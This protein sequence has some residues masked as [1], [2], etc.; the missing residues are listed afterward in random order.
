M[1][2]VHLEHTDETTNIGRKAF[3][4]YNG[5]TFRLNITDSPINCS[6]SW[7]G[8]S[9][10]Y[11]RFIRLSDNQ[12]TE[13]MPAQSAF[14]K[15][16]EGMDAVEIPPGYACVEHCIFQGKDL[17]LRINIHPDNAA[18]MIPEKP[19]MSVIEGIVLQY[20]KSHKNSYGGQKNVRFHAANQDRKYKA[21]A[22]REEYMPITW[23]EWE[24]AKTA[25]IAAGMLKKNGAIT[26][27]GKNA[28]PDRY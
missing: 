12:V 13:S 22:R 16:I 24:I 27:A 23:D 5:R 2:T 17:G 26:T 25:L 8:G 4:G 19:A 10:S 15:R 11:Y 14:D 18:K 21:Q 7:S 6:S 1:R 9:R 28:A 20:S 3:P